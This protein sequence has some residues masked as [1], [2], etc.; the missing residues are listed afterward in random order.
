[1][2][3]AHWVGAAR[4]AIVPS[5]RGCAPVARAVVS[6]GDGAQWGDESRDKGEA[7]RV[8][9]SVVPILQHGRGPRALLLA[10]G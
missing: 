8:A 10:E 5:Q 6:E 3:R 2:Q 7:W 1:V 4:A 9:T